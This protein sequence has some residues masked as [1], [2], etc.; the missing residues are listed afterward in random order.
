M[1]APHHKIGIAWDA[2]P[3]GTRSDALIAREQGVSRSTVRAARLRRHQELSDGHTACINRTEFEVLRSAV[4]VGQDFRRF[5]R[6][7]IPGKKSTID[8][9]VPR[10]CLAGLMAR[11]GIR[12]GHVRRRPPVEYCMTIAGVKIAA[13]VGWIPRARIDPVRVRRKDGRFARH[14]PVDLAIWRSD[15]Y[16]AITIAAR[17]MGGRLVLESS[18]GEH[19]TVRPGSDPA[20]QA[21][22]WLQTWEDA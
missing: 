5:T 2:V 7:D 21:K 22:K 12:R 1:N 19:Q 17:V 14:T 8:R 11:C 6:A 18:W 20:T 13:N 15:R 10:L 9:A 4:D 16:P 3:L